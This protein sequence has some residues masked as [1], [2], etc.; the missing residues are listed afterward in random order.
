MRDSTP[1]PWYHDLSQ[2]R[3]LNR[4]PQAS[5]I[6]KSQSSCELQPGYSAPAALPPASPESSERAEASQPPASQRG[7]AQAAG[8][9]QQ[10]WNT[11]PHLQPPSCA[12]EKEGKE[13]LTALP[14][15]REPNSQSRAKLLLGPEGHFR[16]AADCGGKTA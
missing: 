10:F 7:G 13:V 2:R 1:G 9:E 8:L 4:Q 11:F 5:Q 6:L 15:L 14:G 12:E 16:E 3:T